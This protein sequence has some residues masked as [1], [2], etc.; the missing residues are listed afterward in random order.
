MRLDRARLAGD[1]EIVACNGPCN[2]AC[3]V[4]SE[5]AHECHPG[6]GPADGAGQEQGRMILICDRPVE[7]WSELWRA[8][9]HVN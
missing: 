4:A 2:S 6:L 5:R 8:I 3:A 7:P 1:C 9:R